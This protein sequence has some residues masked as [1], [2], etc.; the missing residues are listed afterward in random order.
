LPYFGTP[1]AG[2]GGG[3][4]F[5]LTA[6]NSVATKV[7]QSVT[8]AV[9]QPTP[10]ITS[11]ATAKFAVG[12]AS[13]FTV[14][15]TG[16]RA[17]ADLGLRV[18]ILGHPDQFHGNLGGGQQGSDAG[19]KCHIWVSGGGDIGRPGHRPRYDHCGD[20]QLDDCATIDSGER[21]LWQGYLYGSVRAGTA[22]GITFV[23]NGNGTETLSGTPLAGSGGLYH[24][25]MRPPL[26]PLRSCSISP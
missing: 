15:T 8:I 14:A 2:T 1:A 21:R 10:I 19:G 24:L 11:A 7:S 6:S 4:T 26:G 13:S 16:Y 20:P 25:T 22:P 17:C 3:Y 18:A 12:Q 9:I 23:D 5:T